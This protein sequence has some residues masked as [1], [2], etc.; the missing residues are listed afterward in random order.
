VADFRKREI[1]VPGVGNRLQENIAIE[2]KSGIAVISLT[3]FDH[4]EKLSHS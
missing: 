2:R 1:I 4:P 3:L